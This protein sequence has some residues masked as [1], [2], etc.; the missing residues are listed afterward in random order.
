MTR[1]KLVAALALIALSLTACGDDEPSDDDSST[2]RSE[3]SSSEDASTSDQPTEAESPADKAPAADLCTVIDKA[4]IARIIDGPVENMNPLTMKVGPSCGINDDVPGEVSAG[5][6]H[7]KPDTIDIATLVAGGDDRK[8]KKVTVAGADQATQITGTDGDGKPEAYVCAE[9]DGLVC[10]YATDWS[11]DHD[12]A[13]VTEM[14]KE[15]AEAL[16]ASR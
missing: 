7:F 12:M 8:T 5:L 10:G 4:E 13:Q 2:P 3:P 11:G 9:L 6:Y 16:I 1:I 14:A 15:L